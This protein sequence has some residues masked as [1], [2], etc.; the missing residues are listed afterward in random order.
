[1]GGPFTE[2]ELRDMQGGSHERQPIPDDRAPVND[3]L[4]HHDFIPSEFAP[5]SGRCDKCGGGPLA[6]IHLKPVDQM[7]RIVDALERIAD[8]MEDAEQTAA[9]RL[10][11]D[12][13]NN[14]LRGL[15]PALVVEKVFALHDFVPMAVGS[16]VCSWCGEHQDDGRHHRMKQGA[17]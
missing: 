8:V 4:P 15:K 10:G 6:P 1:M 3:G 17:M 2:T 13:I 16:I 5:D 11:A 14:L 9:D 12:S 7:A